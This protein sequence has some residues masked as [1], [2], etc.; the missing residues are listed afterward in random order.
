[1]K[2]GLL[3][4]NYMV[5]DISGNADKIAQA[6]AEAFAKGAEV[7]V[8]SELALTAYPPRDLLLYPGII[9]ACE[10]AIQSLAKTV[11]RGKTLCIG[12]PERNTRVVG[13]PLFN[14]AVWLETGR[15]ARSFHKTLLPTY[16]VFDEARYFES[17]CDDRTI[18]WKGKRIGVSI[19]EDLWNDEALAHHYRE[20]PVMDL[21][22][23]NCDLVLNLSASPFAMEKH[24]RIRRPLMGKVARRIQAPLVFV[25]QVGGNDELIFDGRSAVFNENGELCVELPAFEEAVSVVDLASLNP[26]FCAGQD[27]MA[28]LWDA[29]VC[30]IRDYAKKCGFSKALLGISGGID[31]AVTA[32]IACEA[33]GAENVL[34][35]I[36]PSPYSSSASR[37]DAEALAA[38]LGIATHVMAIGSLMAAYDE[39]LAEVFAGCEADVTEENIQSR[40]RGNLLMAIAN[41]T[42]ALLLTTGNKSEFAVGYCTLYGDMSGGLAVISDLLKTQVYALARWVNCKKKTVIPP[43]ILEKPPSAE[44]RPGQI[45]QDMLPPYSILDEIIV[46]R[47]EKRASRD[48]IVAFGFDANTVDR[49]LSMLVRAE[50]KRRQAAP[51]LKVTTQAFGMGWRMPISGKWGDL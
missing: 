12:A 46:L 17:H 42:G 31:S 27:T 23:R 21:G 9:A 18:V 47:M 24:E 45:D 2:I 34:G 19:C 41:K 1:M 37:E 8:T 35:V 43:A 7:V 38:R 15:S 39:V 50:F 32:V 29:L 20:N 14:S 51:G 13:R 30:G 26:L 16:D 40:I 5:G 10:Q 25:N 36:L 3:Q 11:P 4:L 28:Q 49:V 22:E 44:L 6:S 33:L 48:E